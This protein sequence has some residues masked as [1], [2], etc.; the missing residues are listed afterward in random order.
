MR[1]TN[2]APVIDFLRAY[3]AGRYVLQVAKAEQGLHFVA[4]SEHSLADPADGI[5]R[6]LAESFTQLSITKII[7]G[8][9]LA[10]YKTLV[11]AK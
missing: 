6:P 8:V 4:V 3:R 10:S 9:E 1:L 2:P 5:W 7:Y 11:V